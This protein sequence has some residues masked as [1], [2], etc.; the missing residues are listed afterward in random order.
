M[1]SACS[2]TPCRRTCAALGGPAR[3]APCC[4]RRSARRGARHRFLA[5]HEQRGEISPTRYS[6]ILSS[7]KP[8]RLPA[9]LG[10]I[11][12]R[13]DARLPRA[14]YHQLPPR[15]TRSE[16]KRGPWGSVTVPP[17][18]RPY[19]SCTRSIT[20]PSMSYSPH[21]FGSFCPTGC[22]RA[23]GTFVI[24]RDRVEVLRIAVPA[25]ARPCRILPLRL[26]R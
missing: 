9:S 6:P 10:D 13:Y 12:P 22:A 16:P 11:S 15:I 5:L 20:F 14:R 24:P 18:Y 17:G 1:G 25:R 19:Q 23:V 7:R 21:P 3:I 4:N 2:G 26:R 8:T